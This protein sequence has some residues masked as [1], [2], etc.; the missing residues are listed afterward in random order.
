MIIELVSEEYAV[1]GR[2]T[3]MVISVV[4]VTA[5]TFAVSTRRGTAIIA[6][7]LMTISLLLEL[8]TALLPTMMSSV[9]FHLLR[10]V[11]L[12]FIV[13]QVFRHIFKPR[14]VTFDTISASLCIYL[15]LGAVWANIYAIVEMVTP[16]SIVY[17]LPH[18]N[19][20]KITE[21]ARS[22]HMLYFSFVTLSTVGYGD[23]VPTTTVARMFAVTEAISGQI[24]LLVMVSRLVGL[25]VSQALYQPESKPENISNADQTRSRNESS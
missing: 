25:Q 20:Q 6:I 5:A 12:G 1:P 16:G 10:I 2:I 17:V 14:I 9:L 3:I 13:S 11:F 7:V 24:Y 21:I 8:F 22:F 19:E 4:W 18:A 23:M 15:M